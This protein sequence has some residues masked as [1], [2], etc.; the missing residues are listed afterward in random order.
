MH[1][2]KPWL[3]QALAHFLTGRAAGESLQRELV[4]GVWGARC[5]DEEG[6]GSGEM[7]EKAEGL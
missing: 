3:S 4:R 2:I 7:R 1:Q 5:I 6:L